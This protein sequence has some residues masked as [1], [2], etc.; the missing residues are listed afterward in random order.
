MEY[1]ATEKHVYAV[2]TPTRLPQLGVMVS[3]TGADRGIKRR[4]VETSSWPKPD[5]PDRVNNLLFEPVWI[6]Y[7]GLRWNYPLFLS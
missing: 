5:R 7:R 3:L 1:K 2:S 6:Y 4:P